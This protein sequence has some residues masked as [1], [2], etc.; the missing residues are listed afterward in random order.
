MLYGMARYWAALVQEWYYVRVGLSRWIA[1][2][3]YIDEPKRAASSATP[4]AF[5]L[6]L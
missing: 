1:R 6:E 5:E 4:R 2:S 3:L